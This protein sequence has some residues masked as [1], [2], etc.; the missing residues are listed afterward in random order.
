[1]VGFGTDRLARRMLDQARALDVPSMVTDDTPIPTPLE[2]ARACGFE[3]DPWQL[4]V[5]ESTGRKLLLLCSRQS[6]KT[7][8]TAVKVLREAM[9][10][11]ESLI[12]V[13][14]P[15]QRQ[16]A[17]MMRKVFQLLAMLGGDAPVLANE[18]MLRME[19]PNGS[20]VIALPGNENTV[21]GYSAATL[22]VIDEAARVEKQ[23]VDSLRPTMATTNGQLIALTTPKG[24]RGW[25]WEQWSQGGDSWERTQVAAKDCPRISA[26]FLAEARREMGDFTYSQEYENAWLDPETSFFSSE[27]IERMLTKDISPLWADSV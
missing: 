8:T 9:Y 18:S 25:F 10:T 21:R 17:E 13:V 11:P 19:L 3:P 5:L 20:R 7:T 12:L 23:L 14:S 4:G 24:R 1:M 15:A 6:G 22:L 2:F 16:S 27:L 26:E